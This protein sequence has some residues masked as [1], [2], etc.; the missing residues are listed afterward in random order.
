MVP[1]LFARNQKLRAKTKPIVNNNQ[2]LVFTLDSV[3]IMKIETI[4]IHVKSNE[5]SSIELPAPNNFLAPNKPTVIPNKVAVVP[6]RCFI[7]MNA[8]MDV[9]IKEKNS[10]IQIPQRVEWP[11]HIPIVLIK[12]VIGPLESQRPTYNVLPFN[13]SL[14]TY[15]K[16]P[17]SLPG[18]ENKGLAGVKITRLNKEKNIRAERISKY[19]LN[20]MNILASKRK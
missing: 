6:Q 19:I 1:T 2:F 4:A 17:A 10:S 13:N 20:F 5:N 3:H 11:I 8:S 16:K 14:P 15:I 12:N 9:E 18:S 7:T